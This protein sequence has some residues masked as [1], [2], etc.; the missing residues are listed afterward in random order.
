VNNV[1]VV[2]VGGGLIGSMAA[3]MMQRRGLRTVVLESRPKGKEQKVVVG[4]AI[5]EGSSVF[6]R[7][8]IGLGDWLKKNAYRKFGFD[9]LTLPRNAPPPRTMEECHEL[10]LSLTPLEKIPG[11]FGR[12]IPTF[13]VERTGMNAHVA[14]LAMQEGTAYHYGASVERIELGEDPVQGH[15]VH[16]SEG[17]EMRELRCKFVLD[18]SGR[19]SVLGRQLGITHAVAELDTAAVWNRFTNVRSDRAFWS[20]FQGIDRRR[21]TIHFTGPGFWIWWIHQSDELTSVGVSYDKAQ[22]RPDVKTD[23]RGFWEMIRKFP[24][25]V[26]A[27]EGARPV[28]PYQYYA[29]LPYQSEHWVSPRGY[30]LVGD[31]AWF[32]DALYSIGIETACRQLTQLAPLVVDACRG[33]GA[34]EKTIATLN[35]EFALC[36]KAVQKLNAFK[37]KEGW[38]RPHVVMQTAL[39]ELGEIAELYHMQDQARWLPSVLKK[40]YRL[41]WSTPARLRNLERFQE[42]SLADGDR[43]LDEPG[44]LRKALLPGWA[45]YAFT[46]ALWK[47]PHA[48]PYF[49]IL[50]RAWGYAERMAQRTRLFPDGL[51]WMANGPSLTTVVNRVQGYAQRRSA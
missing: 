23:D 24:P 3:V 7:H 46:W 41:Q 49:F 44:L 29:H 31:A 21:H 18:A 42:A 35:E 16:Y 50:T 26:D 48:R 40:H 12:L 32:T 37:Y 4:E 22:H 9:F 13:H 15:V 25:V 39:Y 2:V 20:T 11:A 14:E 28:E 51:S 1:D 36:Q 45:V 19:R 34:C 33:A 5:T 17:G 6:L 27:L 8:E 30:A 38:A 47:L 43:D 10:L